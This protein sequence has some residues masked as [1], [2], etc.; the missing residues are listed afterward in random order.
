MGVSDQHYA[1]AALPPAKTRYPLYMR[2]GGHQG[3][4]W[5]GA[6]NLAPPT[7]IR[8]PDRSA[9]SG[10]LYRLSYHGLHLGIRKKIFSR[11]KDKRIAH[12]TSPLY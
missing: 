11:M 12:G 7:G 9:R 6:E 3:P 5:T 8:S 1:P 10:S 2:L 4:V